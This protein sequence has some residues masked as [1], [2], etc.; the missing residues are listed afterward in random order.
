M[1]EALAKAAYSYREY[2]DSYTAFI[3][4][5][6]LSFEDLHYHYH[7]LVDV[8]ATEPNI[9]LR[10][11]FAQIV[12]VPQAVLT[13]GSVPYAQRILD[14]H[15]LAPEFCAVVGLE[16]V[17][18]HRKHASSLPIAYMAGQMGLA[19]SDMVFVEDSAAN[20]KP[21]FEIGVQT[22]L[23]THGKD[24]GRDIDPQT[25]DYVSAYYPSAEA[26]AEDWLNHQVRD[27]G[28]HI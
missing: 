16:T 27:C 1:D 5:C 13:H 28:A 6:G 25:R 10:D 8:S 3:E 24:L 7:A 9:R 26:F 12:C 17:D 20:L 11:A 19:P 2:G 15:G 23:I 22:V 4:E 18:F 21:A 14:A